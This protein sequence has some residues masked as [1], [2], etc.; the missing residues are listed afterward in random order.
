MV[1]EHGHTGEE[2]TLVLN[3]SYHTDSQFV[4]GDIEMADD[5]IDHQPMID[6]DEECICLVFTSGPLRF[7]SLAAKVAQPFIGL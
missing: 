3:G 4:A 6:P 2:W 7:K 1:P 5:D